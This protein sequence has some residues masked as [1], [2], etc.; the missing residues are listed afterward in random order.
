MPIFMFVIVVTSV[1][2]VSLFTAWL[3][4]KM[5][6]RSVRLHRRGQRVRGKVVRVETFESEGEIGTRAVVAYS[7]AGKDYFYHYPTA[8]FVVGQEV[9]LVHAPDDPGDVMLVNWADMWLAPGC[10]ISLAPFVIGLV[11][12]GLVALALQK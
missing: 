3:G 6:K 8:W 11:V 2:L 9:P 12:V 1:G 5:L 4:S 10:M 7:V